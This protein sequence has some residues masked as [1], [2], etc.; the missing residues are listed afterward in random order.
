MRG[1]IAIERPKLS[2]ILSITSIVFFVGNSA[3]M[4]MYPGMKRING[5]PMMMRIA[6]SMLYIARGE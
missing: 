5:S 6:L 1:T 4:S 3:D 2:A